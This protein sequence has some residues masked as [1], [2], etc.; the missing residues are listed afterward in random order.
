MSNKIP[1]SF[2]DLAPVPTGKTI[3]DGIA[4]TV[5]MAQQAEQVG[6]NRYWMAEHHNM[7]GIASAATSVL[8]SHIGSQTDRIRIGSGGIML[9][10]HAPLMVA[11]QFGTLQALYGDRI[12]LGLGRAPGTD[13]AT[14]Q[15]LRR[16]MSDAERFPQDVQ[17]LMYL[18][19]DETDSSPVQAFPGA[20]SNV[21]IW[22]LGSSLFG[23]TLAAHLG[24]PYVFASHFAPQ[25]LS[26]AIAAYREE[27]KP[28]AYLDKP[29]VMLAANLLLADDDAT[30][31][32]HFTS[33]QQS[34]VRLRR[35]ERGQM[36]KPTHDMDSI[37]SP[38]EKTMVDS[39]LSVSF[40]G[41]VETVKP[42]LADFLAKYEPDELIVTANVY[43]Q[44][45][46]LHS[47]SLVPQLNLFT[48]QSAAALA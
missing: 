32:Y 41:S 36:P 24:L 43:D 26:K 27:F 40:I 7:A 28:S 17:E 42:K 35:N 37:W 47:L 5:E 39:A 14:F 20:K 25:M 21:P 10:N 15:A 12:D 46:R 16:Q 48:L 38:A 19:G 9:P 22:I 4:Q 2:L 34:F 3:A 29:Y 13:G 23:A 44:A 30:A 31:H 1:L 18:L 6:L 45:A 8:L 11:E 33:A